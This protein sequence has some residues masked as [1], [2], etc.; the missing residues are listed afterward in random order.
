MTYRKSGWKHSTALL[1]DGG[2]ADTTICAITN[3]LFSLVYLFEIN[4]IRHT[5]ICT[6][7]VQALRE[8]VIDL[9]TQRDPRKFR[10][11]RMWAC[12]CDGID[13]FTFTI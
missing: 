7:G 5:T 8:G 4:N 2:E 13:Y 6:R 1:R 12:A 10:V 3:Y 9:E 11:L